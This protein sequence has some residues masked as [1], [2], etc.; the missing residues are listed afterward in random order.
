MIGFFYCKMVD[1]NRLEWHKTKK[2]DNCV[3]VDFPATNFTLAGVIV[4]LT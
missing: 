2:V 4:L 1:S 3:T